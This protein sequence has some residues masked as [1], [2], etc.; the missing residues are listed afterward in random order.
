M[1]IGLFFALVSALYGY[2]RGLAFVKRLSPEQ[3]ADEIDLRKEDLVHKFY[4]KIQHEEDRRR[5][6]E[7]EEERIWAERKA[8]RKQAQREARKRFEEHERMTREKERRLVE[9]DIE[10]QDMS[11]L[12]DSLDGE[13]QSHA[14]ESESVVSCVTAPTALSAM[15][16]IV[17]EFKE[18]G[19]FVATSGDCMRDEGL[20]NAHT[21]QSSAEA[22]GDGTL[23]LENPQGHARRED[24]P[25]PK[26]FAYDGDPRDS[27]SIETGGT[28]ETVE[29][30]AQST[31][32]E[33]A[34]T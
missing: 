1:I 21:P 11:T 13:L 8:A 14:L 23:E 2:Y 27:Y 10:W 7:L 30:S 32:P 25:E 29:M 22:F 19:D 24:A 26:T 28:F 17:E 18:P 4:L 12:G 15:S 20:Q 9:E 34:P 33:R 5:R 16:S 6:R 31:L 3:L